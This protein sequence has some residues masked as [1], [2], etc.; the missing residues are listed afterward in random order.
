MFSLVCP[1]EMRGGRVAFKVAKEFFSWTDYRLYNV[2]IGVFHH[3]KI[4]EATLQL[5]VKKAAVVFF[6]FPS[7]DAMAPNT[8]ARRASTVLMT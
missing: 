4:W 7:A 8:A 6:Y 1:A 5:C 2:P 3:L